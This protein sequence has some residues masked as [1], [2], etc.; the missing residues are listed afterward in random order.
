TLVN[1]Y[2]F[3]ALYANIDN[4]VPDRTASS[5][6]GTA[7]LA[8]GQ[9]SRPEIDRWIVSSLQSLVKEYTSAMDAYD[10]TKAARA[11]SDFTIDQLSNWY[12]RRNRRR[13]WS[14]GTLAGLPAGQAGG[15]AE[16]VADKLS[17][18]QTLYECLVTITKLAAPFA[19]FLTDYLYRS[20]G[21]SG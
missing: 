21:Q 8:G 18:Y 3:F 16:Q 10:V 11:V 13:F 20:L 12:V 1:T 6:V 14:K 7:R 9:A 2:A 15:P 5:P 17:A 4:F 19:P